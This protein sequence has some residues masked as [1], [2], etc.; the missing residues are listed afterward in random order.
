MDGRFVSLRPSRWHARA[1]GGEPCRREAAVGRME[2][3]HGG[4]DTL[5]KR[6]AQDGRYSP[7]YAPLRLARSPRR[8][9]AVPRGGRCGMGEEKGRGGL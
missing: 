3:R 5:T 7:L 4:L 9:R 2:R 1:G 6:T 8:M